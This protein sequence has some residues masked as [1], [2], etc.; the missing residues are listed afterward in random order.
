M[1]ALGAVVVLA[2]A[3]VFGQ[4]STTSRAEA[5]ACRPRGARRRRTC[6]A[7]SSYQGQIVVEAH[8]AIDKP[9][10]EL[11]DGW[12]EQMQVNTVAPSPDSE[13][14]ATVA[15]SSTTRDSPPARR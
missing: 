9:V 15:W 8:E 7:G 2:L 1:G 3:N 5:P 6:A 14:R 12:I 13:A 10:I 4:T 11:G